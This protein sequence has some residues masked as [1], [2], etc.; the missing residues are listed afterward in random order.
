MKD[1][2][3]IWLAPLLAFLVAYGVFWSYSV[4]SGL[5]QAVQVLTEQRDALVSSIQER[6]E[7]QLDK[8]GY[9]V[10]LRPVEEE[11]EEE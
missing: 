6:C 1:V 3:K 10:T 2:L 5:N 7:V 4:I 8:A 11:P 9:D